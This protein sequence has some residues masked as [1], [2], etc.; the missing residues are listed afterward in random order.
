M[1]IAQLHG[2]DCG[3]GNTIVLRDVDLTLE[4]GALIGL[5]GPSGVGKTTLLRALLGQVRF[6]KGEGVVNG[7]PIR[8][9]RIPANIGYVPQL[10]TIDWNFPVNVEQVVMMGRIRSTSWLPWP[11]VAD[12][13]AM[14]AI[15]H[16]LGLAGLAQR[17]IR[18]LSG[19][20]QKRVFLAR[21]L[22][23]Q[24]KMLLLD[25]PTSGSDAKTR[26][27]VMALL[28]E[29][30]AQGITIVLTTHDLNGVAVQ[31]PLV[32]CINGTIVASGS[33]NDVFSAENLAATYGTTF[34]IVERNGRL[35]VIDQG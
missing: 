14:E 32:A 25:E 24:P 34:D 6:F 35:L 10:E 9:K 26:R 28:H 3:Y 13:E 23:S 7:T 4:Q 18:E 16:R 20:Q 15:L 8:S 11:T 2:V 30:N 33:P 21:A 22:I 17:S 1:S 29:L 5:V 19:G 27:E 31:L 12:R